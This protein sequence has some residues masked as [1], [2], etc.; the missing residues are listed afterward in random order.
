MSK[1]VRL[2]YPDYQSGGLDTYYL[3]SKLMSCI[4]PKNAEQETLT[5]QI[6]P[7]GTKEYEVTD[8]VYAR[9]TVET[10]IIQGG[11]LLEDAA[12]DRVIT[13][14]GNCLVSQAP[15]DYLHG[16]YD[17]VGIIWIDAHPD[18]ST[19]TDGY[20]Y[21][22]AMV[23]GNLLG[24]GDEKL[25]GLM[26]SP[27]FKPEEVLY[28]G[29]QGLHDY[30]EKFLKN[31]GVRFKVQDTDFLSDEEIIAFMSGFEHILVHLDIDVLN[32]ALFSD[33]YFA[34][35]ELV[36]DGAGGGRMTMEKLAGVLKLIEDHAD[37]VGFTIAEY[38]PFSAQRL[39]NLFSEMQIF[40]K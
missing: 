27:K 38:L 14:G 13:I 35:P 22:H 40:R 2:I 12:P 5:V 7:P 29:L 37:I 15:F 18:V 17:N 21:A 11:K 23:L 25:S 24:G 32:A 20:P 9:E 33:T 16:K 8:G 31:S 10:N 19:P 28:I 3:G 26:K 4:I 39:H 30:Q 1:T 34:N 6:D 36:G